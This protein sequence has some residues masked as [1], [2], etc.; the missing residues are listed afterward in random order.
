MRKWKTSLFANKNI[1][2]GKSCNR[3]KILFSIFSPESIK[4]INAF[5]VI[6]NKLENPRRSIGIRLCETREFHWHIPALIAA[7]CMCDSLARPPRSSGE[8]TSCICWYRAF[9]F[10]H[11]ERVRRG[12]S[13][14]VG[15]STSSFPRRRP[16]VDRSS[17]CLTTRLSG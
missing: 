6:F 13:C 9:P 17:G 3:L 15:I 8:R 11:T 10:F 5:T 1:F 14:R 7:R 12:W 4:T 16:H 2:R